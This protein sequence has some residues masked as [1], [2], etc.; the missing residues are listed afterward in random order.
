MV[1]YKD[2]EGVWV[3]NFNFKV[4]LKDNKCFISD[5]SFEYTI[6]DNEV[7]LVVHG[8]HH[9]GEIELNKTNPSEN[10][11]VWSDGD[12]WKPFMD[13]DLEST[14]VNE[15]D[16]RFNR[17]W[18]MVDSKKQG[19][20]D[21]KR[22]T[23]TVNSALNRIFFE[24]L[25]TNR[26]DHLDRSEFRQMFIQ[27]RHHRT[28]KVDEI[29]EAME[30][31]TSFYKLFKYMDTDRTGEINFKKFAAK[32]NLD[33]DIE[34][35]DK[36]GNGLINKSEFR[37]MFYHTDGLPQRLDKAR[38]DDFHYNIRVLEFGNLFYNLWN[39]LY[40]NE[41][42]KINIEDYSI[43]GKW[44]FVGKTPGL[45]DILNEHLEGKEVGEKSSTRERSSS[46]KE[47]ELE[48]KTEISKSEL[49]DLFKKADGRMDIKKIS[50]IVA[51]LDEVHFYI[52]NV[53]D[54][55]LDDELYVK[56]VG[57]PNEES[58]P[59][60]EPGTKNIKIDEKN[61]EPEE[62]GCKCLVM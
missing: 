27:G 10:Q 53:M 35:Y 22:Y 59:E 51:Y 46:T 4:E 30:A 13:A 33:L 36:D 25:D 50:S 61:Q 58:T 2:V 24:M 47:K 23:V 45:Y 38:I 39:Y 20:V 42:H 52:D 37:S 34:S 40:P 28:D 26:D 18:R 55:C 60:G 21:L 16:E 1:T 5:S 41:Q 11:I 57:E 7:I 48:T 62:G 32:N 54:Y 9:K 43:G 49:R 17:L 3:N 8:T 6:K 44:E 31:E 29:I 14:D 56:K 19:F 15:F 12:V